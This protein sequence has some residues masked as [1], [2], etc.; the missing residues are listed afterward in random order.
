[1][2]RSLSR[3]LERLEQSLK[4]S[5][6]QHVITVKYVTPDGTVVSQ[7][8]IELAPLNAAQRKPAQM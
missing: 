5:S 8:R 4:V 3:R 1:M 2:S 7:R 6:I